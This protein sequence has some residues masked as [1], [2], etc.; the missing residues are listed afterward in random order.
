MSTIYDVPSVYAT[1]GAAIAAIPPNLSGQGVHEVVMEAG[2]YN[3]IVNID[4]FANESADDHIIVR[5]A[6]GAESAGIMDG[7][8]IVINNLFNGDGFKITSDY[9][10]IRDIQLTYTA[11]VQR[12]FRIDANANNTLFLRCRSKGLFNSKGAFVFTG[13]G[14]AIN[15]IANAP[16]GNG[17]QG[18]NA[19]NTFYAYNC[20][21]YGCDDNGF[22]HD[23]FT[24]LICNNCVAINTVFNDFNGVVTGSNNC[25]TDATA[26]GAGS[27]INQ[28]LASMNFVNDGVDFHI[29]SSSV[30]WNVGSYRYFHRDMINVESS[31]HK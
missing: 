26:P 18:F 16:N 4:G 30:L 27:L 14:R 28:T 5:A 15:C 23:A 25:S 21:A 13:H 6:S 2:S 1:L 12:G 22:T 10:Q 17:F 11:T 8:V 9:C 19:N 24:T 20:I 3:E 31:D 29:D 7:G